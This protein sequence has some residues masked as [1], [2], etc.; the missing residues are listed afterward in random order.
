MS[1]I[2]NIPAQEE[3]GMSNEQVAPFHGDKDDK[4]PED[5]LQSFFR[6]MGT[7]TNVVKKQQFPNFL[8]A[9]SV[10]D[11]WYDDL[12]AADKTDWTTIKAAFHKKWPRKQQVKKTQEE[13]KEEITGLLLKMED[14]GKK[15]KVTGRDMYS[16]I[17]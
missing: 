1:P 17:A 12:P 13:Y 10:A 8:Q 16:H 5:F 11:E 14:L 2:P 6:C 9:D 3:N 7:S 15:E 4:N